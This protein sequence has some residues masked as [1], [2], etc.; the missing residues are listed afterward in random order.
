VP[1]LE[2]VNKLSKVWIR[3]TNLLTPQRRLLLAR[4]VAL[5]AVIAI[6]IYV[7]SIR[8]QA[9]ELAK[10]GYPGIF[11]LSILANATV[12]LPAPGI[13]FV[14]FMG[15][16]FN[17]IGVAIAAGLGAAIGEL[18]G[19]LAGFSG[20]AIVENAQYY[21]R[22]QGWMGSNPMIANLIILLLAFIPNPFFDLAGISAG[23]LKIPVPRF[24]FY[25]AIGKILKMFVIAYAGYA[26]ISSLEEI[27]SH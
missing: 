1:P 23:T 8:D 10:Y 13:L 9:K 6:T 5:L 19:Y 4:I 16:V 27:F 14:F 12:L 7:Y 25:C 11:L 2:V 26:G 21:Q 18:S 15:A 20:Q 3:F 24:L 17:P 22:I